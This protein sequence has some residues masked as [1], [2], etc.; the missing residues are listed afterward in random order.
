MKIRSIITAAILLLFSVTGCKVGNVTHA[1]GVDNQSYLQFIQ[2][3][4]T[5]YK[6]GVQV[7]VDNNPAF[8]AQV[9][10]IEKLDVRGNVYAVKEGQ[11]SLK[12]VY[13]GSTLYE[14]QILVG[15]QETK[16]ITLP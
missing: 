5:K 15:N 9:D 14:K 10:K 12:V 2:G 6:G 11:H 7:F 16:K 3:G 13:N 8:T 1:G 4:E